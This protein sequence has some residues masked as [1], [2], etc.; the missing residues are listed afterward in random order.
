VVDDTT[1]THVTL[2][3]TV[4]AFGT[5][6]PLSVIH[7]GPDTYLHDQTVAPEMSLHQTPKGYMDKETFYNIMVNDFIPYVKYKRNDLF[8]K[9]PN[10]DQRAVLIVDGH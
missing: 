4:S 7:G 1:S 2:Y 8:R 6:A 3:I 9:N 10:M 5:V